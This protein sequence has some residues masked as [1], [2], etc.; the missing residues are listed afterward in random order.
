MLHQKIQTD[1][2]NTKTR[3][4]YMFGG[5][6][7]E[8]LFL[9]QYTHI[10]K[11]R[12][13]IKVFHTNGNQRKAGVAILIALSFLQRAVLSGRLCHAD[14]G[15]LCLCDREG[16]TG[17]TKK[18][19]GLAALLYCHCCGIL[20]N[21]CTTDPM[22]SWAPGPTILSWSWTGMFL[23]TIGC[24]FKYAYKEDSIFGNPKG[25]VK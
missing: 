3:P 21:F 19:P 2:M 7:S 25:A 8:L 4:I 1:W 17:H 6:T 12:G 20:N 22:F 14:G 5:H 13:W 9:W 24:D 23:R 18:S 15:M 11:V 10:L 16:F